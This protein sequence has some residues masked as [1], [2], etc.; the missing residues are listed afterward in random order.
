MHDFG[1]VCKQFKH[2]SG[3]HGGKGSLC[4]C[5]RHRAEKSD[6]I[7]SM[8]GLNL[9]CCLWVNYL[10]HI[11]PCLSF[12]INITIRICCILLVMGVQE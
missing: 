2:L 5:N 4:F 1:I 10:D 12:G 3:R 11:V 8:G 7:E 6:D 9:G